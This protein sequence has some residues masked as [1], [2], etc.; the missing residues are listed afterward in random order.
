M[1]H[2][3][4]RWTAAALCFASLLLAVSY[5]CETD[6]QETVPGGTPAHIRAQQPI[7][8]HQELHE[9]TTALDE[10]DAYLGTGPNGQAWGKFLKLADLRDQLAR[11]NGVPEPLVVAAV[12]ERFQ[13][14]EPGM[15]QPRFVRVR[16]AIGA[17][18]DRGPSQR[19]EDLVTL[20]AA[21]KGEYRP[22]TEQ[23]VAAARGRVAIALARLD[24][25]LTKG[26]KNGLAWKKYLL[27]DELSDALKPAGT[28][29][30]D[31]L[32]RVLARF[33]ANKV[34]LELPVFT[35]VSD[36][37]EEYRGL[38]EQAANANAR[39][40]FEAALDKL[41]KA[42][43]A[44][45]KAPSQPAIEALSAAT[46]ELEKRRQAPRLIDALRRAYSH[47]NLLLQASQGFV[48]A[49]MSRVVDET[50]PVRDMILGTDISGTGRT[51][52][53]V[54]IR[55][56]P[57]PLEAVIEAELVGT[58]S[59]RTVG[60]NGPALVYSRGTTRLHARKRLMVND[61]G[62][63]ALG[64]TATA[65]AST[66]ITG[67]GSTKRGL[68]DCLVKKIAQR[69]IPQQKR[70]AERIASRHASDRLG[71]R[72]DG[73]TAA[74][75]ADAESKFVEKFR[76]PLLRRGEFPG[77]L[78]FSTTADQLRLL[79]LEAGP[80]RFAAPDAPPD[81]TGS[82]ELALR[83]H[84]SLVNNLAEGLLAGETIGQKW[85]EETAMDLLG[86]VPDRLKDDPDKE[87]WTMT[88][89]EHRPVTFTLSDG[90]FTL[91]ARGT[92]YTSG[93]RRFDAMDFTIKYRLERSGKAV[94][95][96][97]QGDIEIF[98]PGFVQGRDR[99]ALRHATLRNLMRKRLEKLF[100]PEMAPKGP[101][102]L[103]GE[104]EKVGPLEVTQLIADK[105]WLA[106]A[107][108][109]DKEQEKVARSERAH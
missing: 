25:Y 54:Q 49:G 7:S 77:R 84:E 16:T 101:L 5:C 87:P 96:V 74:Q 105:G 9:L 62:I 106:L 11:P 78:R 88:L 21:A 48:S 75:L 44:Y 81:L 32:A 79:V 99:L 3:F 4:G 71:T 51:R 57:D 67:V 37:L 59:S 72:F 66:Q 108:R 26:G 17:W 34:G 98:P 97:R 85:M 47:P 35:S 65:E 29:K 33:R 10:L 102:T 41:S 52:G 2:R 56:I 1:R 28:F 103:P 12:L 94:K 6:A 46:G 13:S 39:A 107:W 68:V 55:F 63:R 100:E 50:E 109:R 82:P 42:L 92:S 93:D 80:G 18:L 73:Q 69:K 70:Q 91:K 90:G 45:A 8:P 14:R 61:E 60:R 95:A 15:E 53:E 104:W 31:V 24:A 38:L 27:W 40:E 36:S 76:N 19:P 86:K 20:A 64:A 43:A 83:M 30:A 58:N 23:D 22:A 89:A